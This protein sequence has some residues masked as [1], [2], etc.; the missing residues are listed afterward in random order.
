M[1]ER[2]DDTVPGYLEPV[3]EII[4]DDD[5]EFAAGLGKAQES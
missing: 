5:T 4:P 1:V 2:P 3:A